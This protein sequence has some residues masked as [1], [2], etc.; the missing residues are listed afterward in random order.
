M[1]ANGGN[2]QQTG[3]FMQDCIKMLQNNSIQTDEACSC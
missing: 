2:L 1:S 3:R